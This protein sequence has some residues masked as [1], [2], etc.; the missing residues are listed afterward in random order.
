M[1][2]QQGPE[3][4][5]MKHCDVESALTLCMQFYSAFLQGEAALT[6]VV[7]LRREADNGVLSTGCMVWARMVAG[8]F[9][10]VLGLHE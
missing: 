9:A 3:G 2:V 4:Y 8:E 10:C 6:S 1:G 7:Y 5:G